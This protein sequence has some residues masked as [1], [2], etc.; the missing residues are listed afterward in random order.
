MRE[1]RVGK[2]TEAE[3]AERAEARKYKPTGNPRG[4]KRLTDAE[5]RMYVPTGN[6]RGRKKGSTNLHGTATTAASVAKK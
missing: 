2:L 3:R 5:P 1:K 4:R 6:P